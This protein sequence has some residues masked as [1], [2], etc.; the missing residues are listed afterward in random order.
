MSNNNKS[1]CKCNYVDK[2]VTGGNKRDYIDNSKYYNNNENN[3]TPD[4]L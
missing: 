2:N 3:S 4:D 1:N